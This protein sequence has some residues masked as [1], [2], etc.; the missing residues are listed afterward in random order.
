M[1]QGGH[2]LV[3]ARKEGESILIQPA[4]DIDPNMTIRELFRQPIEVLISR[5]KGG[6][7]RVGVK[8]PRALAVVREELEML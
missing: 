4:N 7:V 3:L 5:V 2:M 8:A 1:I 6:Q